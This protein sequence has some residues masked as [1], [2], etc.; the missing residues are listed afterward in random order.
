MDGQR[1]YTDSW[2]YALKK[3]A[4]VVGI[5]GVLGGALFWLGDT[6]FETKVEARQNWERADDRIN[7][8]E[9]AIIGMLKDVQYIREG[10]TE[11][12]ERN[13]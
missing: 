2:E 4:G 6:R 11:L 1:R 7:K 10:I 12:K 8:N 13:R 5:L 9:A 3:L